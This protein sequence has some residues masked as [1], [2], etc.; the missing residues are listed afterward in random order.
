MDTG[1]LGFNPG[2][3]DFATGSAIRGRRAMGG[4]VQAGAAYLVGENGPEVLQMG[5]QSGYV[6]ANGAMGGVTLNSAPVIH[7]DARAD[8]AQVLQM[9]AA[10]V[11][12]GNRA[13]L[14]HLRVQGVVR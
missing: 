10:G 8:Q 2:A 13:L 12:Q 6:H 3:A 4:P 11:Q 5:G 7:I 14:E 1:G 9:V